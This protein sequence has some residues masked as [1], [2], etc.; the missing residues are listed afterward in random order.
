MEDFFFHD[1][2]RKEKQ[3]WSLKIMVGKY[4][5]RFKSLYLACFIDSDK[6]E[7][8]NNKS[9]PVVT[10]ELWIVFVSYNFANL[11]FSSFVA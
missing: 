7:H 8:F 10:T 11:S 5:K 3:S 6:S 9:E 1:L 2:T 4:T